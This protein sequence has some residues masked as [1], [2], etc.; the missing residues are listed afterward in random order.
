M[1]AKKIKNFFRPLIEINGS[2]DGS[3]DGDGSGYGDG[4]GSGYGDGSGDGSGSGSGDGS[5]DGSG[6]GYG[7][8]DGS[9]YGYGYGSGDGYGDGSG[10]GY[11]Y[12][13]GSGY[14]VLSFNKKKVYLIDKVQ[15]IL[16]SIKNDVAKGF[17]L[18]SDLTLSP[19]YVVRNE[20]H[21]SHGATIKEALK[22]LEEKTLQKMPIAK[23]IENFKAKFKD[24]NKK[25]KASIFYDWHFKLT[26]SCK[27]GRD[28]FVNS[29]G[30]NL[31]TDKISVNEFI[32][33]TKN[34]Y[35]GDI[36][37]QLEK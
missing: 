18:N 28:N 14:G 25:F 35:N 33:L 13:Y 36:I 34:A 24:Y 6:Y 7:S 11:G 19:C 20:Y 22:S 15:T 12:G 31:A 2:G 23:R 16:E 29:K 37:K 17:I 26:G 5:G 32:E 3:G 9:G 30:I 21:Y 4:D 27:M 10:D 8:G 1:D